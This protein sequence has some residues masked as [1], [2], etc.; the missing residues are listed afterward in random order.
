MKATLTIQKEEI[1]E[2][3]KRI[4]NVSIEKDIL[5]EGASFWLKK[6]PL[7]YVLVKKKFNVEYREVFSEQKEN[8]DIDFNSNWLQV[9]NKFEVVE[10]STENQLS[11]STHTY[12]KL[13]W[14]QFELKNYGGLVIC[15]TQKL[16]NE[17]FIQEFQFL[18]TILTKNLVLA[19][20]IVLN[21]LSENFRANHE[22]RLILLE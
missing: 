22:K 15:S 8:I 10:I 12:N 20:Y 5:I 11:Y 17:K 14:Y 6:F 1:F 18:V 19:K 16:P 7:D 4:E 21:K 2:F 9:K 3:S 13:H